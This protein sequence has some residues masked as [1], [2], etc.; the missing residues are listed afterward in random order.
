MDPTSTLQAVLLGKELVLSNR[1]AELVALMSCPGYNLKDH[2]L[3][4]DYT[5]KDSLILTKINTYAWM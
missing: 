1:T 2:T 4:P 3:G 5:V